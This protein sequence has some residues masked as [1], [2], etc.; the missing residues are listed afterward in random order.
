MN[1]KNV[2]I[3]FA[4]LSLFATLLACTLPSANQATEAPGTEAPAT[5][6][7]TSETAPP[8]QPTAIQH[9]TIPVGLPENQSGQA[10]DFD[11]SGVLESKTAIGGDRFTF[12]RFERPFNANTMDVYYSQLDIVDT[13]VFQDDIWIFGNMTIKDLTASSSSTEKYALELDVTLDGKGDWL[14]VALKPESTD[15]TVNGVKIFEDANDDVGDIQPML[16]DENAT[17]GDGFEKLIFSAGEGDDPD[18]AWVR[19]SPNDSNTVEIAVKQS[20]LGSP[21]KYLINMWAGTNL[22]DPAL[23]DLNDHFT[24]EQ[25]GA[26]DRGF[27]FFYPIKAVYEIDNSCRMAVGFQA[28]GSEPGICPLPQQEQSGEPVPPG[29]SCP[30]GYV[31]YCSPNGCVCRGPSTNNQFP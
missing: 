6:Q 2:K 31:L 18:S 22:L 11:S 13:K 4:V 10:G 15:W 23:F 14:I 27:E 21:K 28:N 25:A 20:V 3:V 29:S 24:H 26:A 19:I 9:Q 16:T 30:E 5:E 17:K 7:V 1:F 12:G 8:A